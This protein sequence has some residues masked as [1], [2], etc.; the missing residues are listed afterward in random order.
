MLIKL[1][2]AVIAFV[3]GALVGRKNPTLASA[4]AKI[5]SSFKDEAEAA[6]AKAKAKITG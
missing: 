5:V 4:A 3:A 2:I 1:L 6:I